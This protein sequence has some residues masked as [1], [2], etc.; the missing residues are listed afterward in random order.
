[1]KSYRR[2][3]S[4]L[5]GK[6][7]SPKV[8]APLPV[9]L[10]SRR[11]EKGGY[12]VSLVA[13]GSNWGSPSTPSSAVLGT[14]SSSSA[15]TS[16]AT[17][18][19]AGPMLE[20]TS[21]NLSSGAA[22]TSSATGHG[23][24]DSPQL[25]PP[26]TSAAG[27]SPF[28]KPAPRAWGV[29]AHTQ[30]H[31]L[32][33]YPT[34]AEAAKK[35]LEQHELHQTNGQAHH[36]SAHSVKRT[37][38]DED[39]SVDFLNAEAIEFADGSVI[40]AAAV[41]QTADS[42]KDGEV[43]QATSPSNH[44]EERVVDRVDVDFNR[45]WPSRPQPN[46]GP[47]LYQPGPEPSSRFG[48]PQ[49][50]SS[51]SLWQEGPNDRDRRPSADRNASHY[52]VQRRESFGN[53]DHHQGPPRRDSVGPKDSFSGPRRDSGNYREPPYD[54]RDS[55]SRSG[56][57]T[58]DREPYHHRDNDYSLDRR[59]SH[60]R[61]PYT[62]DR[63][64]DRHQRDFQLLTR[65][66]EALNDRMGPHDPHPNEY[67]PHSGPRSPYDSIHPRDH[68]NRGPGH[69]HMDLPEVTEYDRPANVTEDQRETMKQAAEEARKR[70]EEQ[71][72]KYQE[73]QARARARAE[74][75]ARVVEEKLVK[76]REEEAAKELERL[77][78]QKV[79][80]ADETAEQ[81]KE[82]DKSAATVT[83]ATAT[84]TIVPE[85][86]R[87]FGN[88]RDRPHLKTMTEGEKREAMNQWKALPDRLVKEE[89]ER[90]TRIRKARLQKAEEEKKA[91]EASSMPATGASSTGGPWRRSGNAVVGRSASDTPIKV[92]AKKPG[93]DGVHISSQEARVE[94]VDKIMHRIE[95]TL[96][97]R[98]NTT[99]PAESA[100]KNVPD[101]KDTVEHAAPAPERPDITPVVSSENTAED[102][103]KFL[104]PKERTQRNGKNGRMEKN[105]AE[106][107]LSWRKEEPTPVS[108]EA[109]APAAVHESRDSTNKNETSN[110]PEGRVAG[111][112]IS[113]AAAA[114][115]GR[116]NYPAKLDGVNGVAKV[117]DVSKIH[118]RLS[119][120]AA[121]DV[122]VRPAAEY[123]HEDKAKATPGSH[124]R[125]DLKAK[126]NSLLNSTTATIFPS[127]VE[128]AAKNRG[129]MSFMVD[130]EIDSPSSDAVSQEATI[131]DVQPVMVTA[132]SGE[133]TIVPVQP[134][135]NNDVLANDNAKKAW[136]ST[137]TSEAPTASNATQGMPMGPSAMA[138]FPMMMPFYPQG[139]PVN[140]PPHMYYMYP[141]RGPMPPPIAQ[142]PGGVVHPHGSVGVSSRDGTAGSAPSAG[143]SD[144]ASG[145][146]LVET[147]AEDTNV[148]ATSN[149][150][151]FALSH[152]WLPRFSAAGDA[153]SQSAGL[154]AITPFMVPVPASQQASML[155]AANANRV[156]QPRPYGQHQQHYP[157]LQTSGPASLETSFQEG[158]ASSLSKSS[159]DGWSATTT[160][161]SASTETTGPSNSGSRGHAQGSPGPP[162]NWVS[163]NGRMNTNGHA[164]AVG[165]YA[166]YQ[167]AP[168]SQYGHGNSNHRGR[169]GFNGGYGH[170]REFRPR[171][172]Y[173]GNHSNQSH[174]HDYN[175]AN[176]Q[177]HTSYSYG[178]QGAAGAQQQ[179]LAPSASAA[180]GT[181]DYPHQSQVHGRAVSQE[182]SNSFGPSY[183]HR[184]SHGTTAAA[185]SSGAIQY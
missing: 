63:F 64:P 135:P 92:D 153:P 140:A 176:G 7:N 98:G 48:G 183:S 129:R 120:Q 152:P 40:V 123:E 27:S 171:G 151:S 28:Q 178:Q 165:S 19:G 116:D 162:S 67:H 114:A 104:P 10:P 164:G 111:G 142:F 82:D 30:E 55:F 1:M 174:H 119:Q 87:E 137:L 33:E 168:P 148:N 124:L 50:R 75:M 20:N 17:G 128:K 15:A 5:R 52:S 80:E 122:N 177:A 37:T 46:A 66:K 44:R 29:V 169:G 133:S 57:Y 160:I 38:A 117:S 59:P 34:A 41:A 13:S 149:S 25:D 175:G 60:D 36:N 43:P 3:G 84:A 127:D 79:V 11:Q 68:D 76:A 110:K 134:S 6:P 150:A 89:D 65:P 144:L 132:Q 170:H 109:T 39:E 158:A 108:T 126:R 145:I 2:G 26:S 181:V 70:R 4:S 101:N 69:A 23:G 71:E 159:T 72:R 77:A 180:T 99:Q 139:F 173:S 100:A 125:P 185:T 95:E 47:S 166:G 172:G 112:R 93:T 18:A 74:E 130:S 105:Q 155:A 157:R 184:S 62:S 8:S 97:P 85:T 96:H 182:G 83:A 51:H 131:Q 106:S 163:G 146:V 78:K 90:I 45:S 35:T 138:P 154:P 86:V 81:S 147:K 143:S 167:Q 179:G 113:R 103:A 136:D 73:S 21:N 16:P 42:Q 91:L 61:P 94:Q 12:D 121:G 88:P 115:I 22:G 24:S 156:P 31:H 53:R 107:V 58:R 118:A 32:D 54:R 102:A 14:S 9:N 141:P 49:D 161:V 56:S